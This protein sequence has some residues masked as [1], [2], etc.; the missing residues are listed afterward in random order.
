MERE[1]TTTPVGS[2]RATSQGP[3]P[4]GGAERA[5]SQVR[6]A[7]IYAWAILGSALVGVLIAWVAANGEQVEVNWLIGSTEAALAV[8]IF[9][10]ALIGWL[11]GIATS[12]AIRR[13]TRRPPGTSP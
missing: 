5:G 7:R 6:R 4:E 9:V 2:E 13:R 1:D 12:A 11:L 10:A 8:V 3:G